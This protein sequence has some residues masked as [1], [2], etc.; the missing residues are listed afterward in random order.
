MQASLGAFTRPWSKAD[1]ETAAGDIAS[2]GFQQAGLMK[3]GGKLLFDHS[4]GE[5]EAARAKRVF[6]THGLKVETSLCYFDLADVVKGKEELRAWVDLAARA[7]IKHLLTTG[8]HDENRY[9]NYFTAVSDCAPYAAGK[10]VTIGLKF[11][12]GMTATGEQCLRA[13]ERVGREGFGIWYD[14]GNVVYY[15]GLDP[16]EELEPVARDTVGVCIKDCRGGKKGSVEVTPGDGEVDFRG[17]FQ[18]LREAG[19]S[20]PMLVETLGPGEVALEA[21]R[22][23]EFLSGLL[24]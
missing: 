24:G 15:D 10:G 5:E 23:F 12:G 18:R 21:R 2:A 20:G 22:A 3:M 19:F 14:P 7:G 4:S 13:V 16:L 11:H 9:E 6:E 8:T 17:I 1:L